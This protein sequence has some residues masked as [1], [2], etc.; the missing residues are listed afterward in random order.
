MNIRLALGL[1]G[2][3][4]NDTPKSYQWEKRLYWPVLLATLLAIFSFYMTELSGEP[5]L[6]ELGR[7]LDATVMLTFLLELV[8]ML[9]VCEQKERYLLYNWLSVAIIAATAISVLLPQLP[10][11]LTALFRLMRLTIVSLLIAQ[12]AHSLRAITPGSTPYILLI[13]FGLMLLAGGGFYWL[14]PT[15]HTYWDG[16]WLAFVSGMTVG[17]GD[18]VP[19]TGAARMFAGLVIVLTY[20]VMSLVTASIAAFFIGKEE[21]SMRREMHQEI[22]L[23]RHDMSELREMMVDLTHRRSEPQADI[24]PHSK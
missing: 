16:V 9:R 8:I 22:K 10:G 14:E 18:L 7:V 24:E 6:K 15:I 5:P 2:V 23:L 12:L 1:A 19:T 21:K 4:P 11:E 3:P 20:G 17:Y 13:G